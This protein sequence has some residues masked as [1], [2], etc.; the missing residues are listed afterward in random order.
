MAREL[1]KYG[2]DVDLVGPW[3]DDYDNNPRIVVTMFERTDE[4]KENV[5][6]A[7]FP[8]SDLEGTNCSLRAHLYGGSKILQDRTSD[9]S[10]DISRLD[11]MKEVWKRLME[12]H[13]EKEREAGG[14]TV[15]AEVEALAS[16][17]GVS[18]AAIQKALR[19]YSAEKRQQILAHDAVQ[20]KAEEIR[21]AREQAEDINLDSFAA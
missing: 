12:D 19:N 11:A 20:K 14:P 9:L 4:G 13:W 7:T 3:K 17:Q 2:V 1:S 16:L 18:I 5:D 10:S 15:S 21:A 6:E 8:L